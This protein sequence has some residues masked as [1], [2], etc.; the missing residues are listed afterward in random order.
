MADI[1]IVNVTDGEAVTL[2]WLMLP[3]GQLDTSQELVTAAIVALGTDRRALDDDLLPGLDENEDRR[4]WWGD[5]DAQDIWGGW[6]I[7]TRLW[8]LSREKIT[9]PEAEQGSTVAR[10]EDYVLEALLPFVGL[11]L[12]TAVDCV[13]TRNGTE[14][15]SAEATIYRGNLPAIQL[16]FAD[17]WSGIQE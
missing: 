4:G 15:I 5:T 1:R 14:R 2:D 6:P 9:G 10:V 7:G 12:A 3:T 8:L 17:H 16:R 13:A 11:G